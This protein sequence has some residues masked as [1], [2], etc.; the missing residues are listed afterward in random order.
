MR[1]LILSVLISLLVVVFLGA[2]AA[3]PQAQPPSA[4]ETAPASEPQ[5]A[6]TSTPD[7]AIANPA[8]QN[9][10]ALGGM[11]EIRTRSDGAQYG[12]CYFEDNRQC[13]EWALLRGDCPVGG[14]KIT[15]YVTD[16]AQYC[17]ITG[18]QYTITGSGNTEK[19]Q[20]TCTFKAG[21]TCDAWDY[22]AGT[23]SPA[24]AGQS[25][26]SDPFVYC[27]AVGTVDAPDAQYDGTAM[28][29]AIVQAMIRQ[30]IV[31]ADAPADF[32]KNAVW[33]CM[34]GL[35]WVCHFGANLPCQEKADSSQVPSAAMQEFCTANPES[36]SIPA[37]VTG[38]ATVYEWKCAG[39][40]PQVVSQV[41]Q[42]DPRGYLADFWYELPTQ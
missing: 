22:F 29:D 9:C 42:V 13:E 14:L 8:S 38:R 1:H 20:G 10:V 28:P 26:Y 2:C 18:G 30:G 40:Q 27:A 12:I 21:Q 37:A 23:C 35:V 3:G 31:T 32:Q 33:R 41:F 4:Q 16:A 7:S 36:E 34:A 11:L 25:T 19:E 5:A 6:P 24:A 39:G 15:G 17:A